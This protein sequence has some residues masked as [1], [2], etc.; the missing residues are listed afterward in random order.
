MPIHVLINRESQS[1]IFANQAGEHETEY[2]QLD[3]EGDP[4]LKGIA[5]LDLKTFLQQKE[6]EGFEQF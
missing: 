6:V 5:T 1:W 2:V 4:V 3:R